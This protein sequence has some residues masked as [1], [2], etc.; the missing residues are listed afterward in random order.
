MTEFDDTTAR[1]SEAL[2][3]ATD[4]M[5][6]PTTGLAAVRRRG[7][8]R[9]RQRQ[10]G[11]AVTCAVA[12]VGGGALTVQ[13]LADEPAR[14]TRPAAP[15][16]GGSEAP[17][18]PSVG[19]IAPTT[20]TSSGTGQPVNRVE[21]AFVWNM[22]VPGSTEAVSSLMFGIPPT[23]QAPYL[24]WSTAPGP[25]VDGIYEPRLYQSDDGIHWVPATTGGTFTE[26][27][28]SRRGIAAQAG[29]IFAFGTAAATAAIPQG[30][31]GDAVVDISTDGG[32]SWQHQVLPIDLRGLAAMD[33]VAGVG[34]AGGL[35]AANGVVVAV[36][37]PSVWWTAANTGNFVVTADGA[38]R[39]TYPECDGSNICSTPT[40]VSFG[41]PTTTA[42]PSG[43]TTPGVDD[44][45]PEISGLIPFGDVGIDPA[46]VA[47]AL[48]PR[49]F[50]STDG[51]TFTEGTFPTLPGGTVADGGDMKVFAAGGAFYATISA[52][53]FDPS[54]EPSSG[55]VGYSGRQLTYRSVDGVT[56]QQL[57]DGSANQALLGVLADGTLVGQ[58]YSADGR[59]AITTST[60]GVDWQAYDLSP[61]ADP[62]DGDITFVDAWVANVDE[63][64]ITV[65]GSISNDPIAEAG[66]RTIEHD[67]VRLEVRSS[68]DGQIY[69]Y[70]TATGEAIAQETFR[71]N[72]TGGFSVPI[73]DG[74]L[75]TFTA[76][77]IQTLQNSQDAQLTTRVLLHSD[78]GVNWS[79]ENLSDLTG[80]GSAG[81]GF[82]QE[83]DGKLLVT[84][85]DPDQRS[86]T[87]ATT[88]V[89]VGTRK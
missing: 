65:V 67:G 3:T 73:P 27:Q 80:A 44:T 79:R 82:I 37:Q 72:E 84:L 13:R 77:E 30:G 1:I 31:A 81:P 88:L 25:S 52:T 62:S 55:N 85:V 75:A 42:S 9:R 58:T 51:V 10:A 26:P 64:G 56:W 4:G 48:T 8:T 53:S 14:S 47:A 49:A 17:T 89:L 11:V 87:M 41:G 59:I 54:F 32:A 22:V 61:L 40:T 71:W 23:K 74:G 5:H 33:G 38:Y 19:T 36:A 68:R 76:A 78:D 35:A 12:L 34:M 66:G 21:P 18:T 6:V 70:D 28:V 83:V 7:T 43:S 60:D 46:S 39:I 16:A 2:R 50:F 24:A 29:S 63:Q 57:G 15:P 69:A 86:D 45:T 20:S